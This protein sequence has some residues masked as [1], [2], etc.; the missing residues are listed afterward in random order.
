MERNEIIRTLR[1]FMDM[2]KERYEIIRI[3]LF[4][5]RRETA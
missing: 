2:N 1:C 4:S 3:G 5:Q